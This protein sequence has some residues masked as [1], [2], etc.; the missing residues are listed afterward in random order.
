MQGLA[1]AAA[2][3]PRAAAGREGAARGLGRRGVGQRGR[4]LLAARLSV[5]A[6]AQRAPLLAELAPPGHQQHEDEEALQRAERREHVLEGQARV[7]DGQVAEDPRQ[8][9]F[10]Q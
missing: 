10:A 4:H 5:R 1:A 9:W 6:A 8:T 2:A 3:A 7:R